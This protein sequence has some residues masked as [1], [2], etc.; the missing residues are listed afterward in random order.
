MHEL[1]ERYDLIVVGGGPAGLAAAV[2][3]YDRGMKDV[4]IVERKEKL[5]GILGQCIHTGFGVQIFEE[6]LTGPE[7]A[8]NFV[9]MVE[10]RNIPVVC[11]A[12][13]LAIN[14]DRSITITGSKCGVRRISCG[15]LVLS[16]GCRERSRGSIN[17]PGTRPSGVF[18][19]GLAQRY[20]NLEGYKMGKEVVIL[21]SG[22]IGLIMARRL[23]LEGIKVRMVC[24]LETWTNGLSRNIVQCLEDFDIPLRLGHTVTEIHGKERLTGV[25]ISMVDE[26]RKP[27]AGTE[28]LIPCDTLLLSV[29][30]IPENE[31][32]RRA[33]ISID[34]V[35]GGPLVNEHMQ[36]SLPWVFACGNV[37][38]V[39]DLVDY[40]TL[41]SRRAASAAAAYVKKELP[42]FREEIPTC[43]AGKVRYVVPQVI[44]AGDD[45]QG[46]LTLYFRVKEPVTNAI[47]EVSCGDWVFYR[48]KKLKMIP[49][50]MEQVLIKAELRDTF[51]AIYQENMS[52]GKIK[53]GMDDFLILPKS[54]QNKS[55]VKTELTVSVYPEE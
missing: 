38:H 37:V 23:T 12:T 41:E 20:I 52:K 27:I 49:G 11:G 31:L 24:E 47:I 26:N 8:D 7:Y 39:H 35:T 10:E 48:A 55:F 19:A 54:S 50:E 18:T 25:T 51:D 43:S 29:G 17:I 4:L 22:D 15:A 21:G 28:E 34:P 2:Q 13:V 44:T 45:A 46:D 42:R 3:A 14:Q 33:G 30:L 6:E 9:A 5:G 40:V 16:M 36:T 1:K 32:T 53:G